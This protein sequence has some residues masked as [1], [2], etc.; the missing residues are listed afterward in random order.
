MITGHTHVLSSIPFNDYNG[1]RWGVQTGTLAD[2][3][4]QQFSY[5]E[6]TPKDWNSGFI[7]MT[8]ERKQL[9][10]P[11][12]IRVFGEDEIEFRGKIHAV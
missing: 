10:Q 7:M 11:E 6:D 4:G 5:T 12:I 3:N 1:T 8:F 2:P 9:L